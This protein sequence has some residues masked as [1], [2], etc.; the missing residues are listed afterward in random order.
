MIGGADGFFSECGTSAER[1][2]PLAPV[3]EIVA[4]EIGI[5]VGLQ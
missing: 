1:W 2:R 3:S 4:S 5:G